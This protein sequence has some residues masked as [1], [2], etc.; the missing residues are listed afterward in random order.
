V[1]RSSWC[2]ILHVR[3]ITRRRARC[4]RFGVRTPAARP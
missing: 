4:V 1:T 3:T 2:R